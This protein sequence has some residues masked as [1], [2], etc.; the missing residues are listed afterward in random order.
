M[1]TED[2]SGIRFEFDSNASVR[3]FDQESRAWPAIDFIIDEQI[4]WIWLEIK[5]WE[6]RDLPTRLRGPRR[7][8]F[9]SKMKSSTFFRDVLRA[10]F[11]GTSAYLAHKGQFSV[12]PLEYIIILESPRLDSSMLI[13][14]TRKMQE[15]IRKSDHPHL[16]VLVM[17]V[18][19]WNKRYSEHNARVLT[20]SDV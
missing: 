13:Q 2:E 4:S 10:K 16:N 17:N 1:P 20:S 19:E 18:L 3:K 6:P 8:S 11:L 14:A 7:R 12:K 9:L 15:L 5:N